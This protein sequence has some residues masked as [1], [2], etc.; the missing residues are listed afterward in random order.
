LPVI[1]IYLYVL[2]LYLVGG[3]PHIFYTTDGPQNQKKLG[4][5]SL[6]SFIVL[7]FYY[8]L[9]ITSIRRGK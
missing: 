2:L 7:K 8:D 9:N 1:Y 3:P 5:T 4:T 6:N